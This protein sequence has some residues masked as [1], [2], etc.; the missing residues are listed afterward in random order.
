MKHLT[1]LKIPANGKWFVSWGGD[2]KELNIHHDIVSQR[3]A[4]DLIGTDEKGKSYKNKG[5]KN[6]DYYVFGQPILAPAD[7]VI[8]EAVTGVHDNLPKET[9]P[10]ASGGN[11]ILIK[12]KADE[13]S[14]IAHLRNGSTLVKA[15]DEVKLNQKL[16]EC[17]NSGNSSEPHIHYHL[18][19][20]TVHSVFDKT[21]SKPKAKGLKV[22]FS[23]VS[24][25]KN[26]RQLNKKLY[27]PVQSDII[28]N[29]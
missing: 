22:Y 2:T 29:S 13:Y 9:N 5:L 3:Y 14:F 8:I 25:I 26:G 6:E 4:F 10:F 20:S 28:S 24:V 18:Q 1:Q 27:S 15:G 21:K 16:G 11:Y 12:H 23:N 7:G 19:N 17:G